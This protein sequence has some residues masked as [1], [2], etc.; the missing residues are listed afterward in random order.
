MK[1]RWRFIR[2]EEKFKDNV[3]TVEHRHYHYDG[4]GGSMPFTVVNIKN[5]V[6]T[7]PVTEDGRLVLVRQFRAGTDSVTYEFPGGALDDGETPEKGA[8]RELEEETGYVA[9]SSKSLGEIHP[10]PAFMTNKC[11]CFLA[12]GCKRTGQMHLDLFEDTE[13][14]EFTEEEVRAMIKDGRITHSISIAAFGLWL[15]DRG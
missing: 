9:A 10:N 1:S 8:L 7:I 4:A 2:S 14:E 11:C 6:I 13:P 3:L 5:W 12:E 15:V